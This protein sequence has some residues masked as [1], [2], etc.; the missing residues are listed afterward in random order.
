MLIG[1]NSP[2]QGFTDRG[3]ATVE[4]AGPGV[5]LWNPSA[6]PS[7]AL[8]YP[9]CVNLV[10][11][12]N[13]EANES[14][15]VY[16]ARIAPTINKWM[17]VPN[18]VYVLGNEPDIE[19]G[20]NG[21]RIA[22]IADSIHHMLPWIKVANPPLSVSRTSQMLAD[23]CDAVVCHTYFERQHPE[24]LGNPLFGASYTYAL[25]AAAGRPVYV[26]EIN[27]VQTNCPIDWG[28]RNKQLGQLL[29]AATNSGVAGA[30]LF[31]A[32]ASPDWATYD[33]GPE[34][35][36]D[37]LVAMAAPVPPPVP[38]NPPQP[39]IPPITPVP[40]LSGAY[41]RSSD[42][43]GYNPLDARW[44]PFITASNPVEAQVICNTYDA[45]CRVIGYDANCAIAQGCVETTVF[46]SP[47]WQNAHAA[48]GVGIYSDGT[49][50][51]IWGPLPHGDA[52][53]GIH[54]QLDLLT[55]Y[56]TDDSEP[57]GTLQP[58]G[59]GGMPPGTWKRGFAMLSDLDG[60]WAAD[61]G[62]SKAIVGYLAEVVGN[63]VI[64]TPTWVT[65]DR[66]VAQAMVDLGHD[67]FLDEGV[68]VPSYYRCE[69][70]V[71]VWE[72]R[73]GLSRLRYPDAK[74]DAHSSPLNQGLAPIGAR[75][76]FEGPGWSVYDHV[77]LSLGDGRTIS[78]LT[79]V[80]ISSGWQ[81]PA[82]GY[83]GWRYAPGVG[84]VVGPIVPLY[85]RMGVPMVGDGFND[86][87]VQRLWYG[88][89]TPS[90]TAKKNFPYNAAFGIEQS[91]A[92][93]LNGTFKQ[94]TQDYSGLSIALGAC[95]SKE[96]FDSGTPG[97]SVRYFQN[98]KLTAIKNADG[99]YSFKVD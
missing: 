7:N 95:I 47:R 10:R 38:P 55:A 77:G 92:A 73:C 5:M 88:T 65:G 30:C 45:G 23:H 75:V 49:P 19:A 67:T 97:R 25:A 28:D 80:T 69:E 68:V 57:F 96:E 62:Y 31:I 94:G 20:H 54:A 85:R 64:V 32:D 98:G 50:D 90:A 51:V 16:L 34:A 99:S 1:A 18:L 89:A 58:H 40:P 27:V 29:R 12:D 74:T 41:S 56:F 17:H 63:T 71:E 35:M 37:I 46:T 72:E 52:V 8:P 33:V 48:A 70:A 36:A 59:F 76:F 9:N 15:L 93:L 81:D 13:W 11:C 42:P 24:D 6:D 84:P 78:A 60:R 3:R 91:Y 82:V 44:L 21:E 87:E 14:P 26:T 22:E 2:V 66:V 39:P 53:T 79:V 86:A 43:R 4:V 61:T 83:L